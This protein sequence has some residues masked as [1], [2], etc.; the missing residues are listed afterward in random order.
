[1][2]R[3]TAEPERTDKEEAKGNTHMEMAFSHGRW[4]WRMRDSSPGL[5]QG[6]FLLPLCASPSSAEEKRSAIQTGTKPDTSSEDKLVLLWES[7]TVSLG[8]ESTF[9]GTIKR[10][11]L[12]QLCDNPGDRFQRKPFDKNELTIVAN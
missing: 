9:V 1:M 3:K 7:K 6:K 11:T 8:R 5:L 10:Q 4:V 12:R 2:L